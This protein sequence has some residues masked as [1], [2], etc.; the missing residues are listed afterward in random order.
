MEKYNAQ[1]LTV[2]GEDELNDVIT[3]LK[4]YGDRFVVEMP[5]EIGIACVYDKEEGIRYNADVNT[6]ESVLKD[7]TK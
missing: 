2:T 5:S 6:I 4:P 1:D 3:L 7:I